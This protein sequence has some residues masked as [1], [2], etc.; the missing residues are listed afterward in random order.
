MRVP[1][2]DLKRIV[3][4]IREEIL[5]DW[6][7]CLDNTEFVGGPGVQNLEKKLEAY[8]E[9]THVVA[10]A[11]GTDALVIGL[12][13]M[14]IGQGHKVAVPNMT[15]WAPY[16]A[17]VQVGATPV[18][19]DISATDLQMNFDEFKAGHEKFKFDAAIL[20][21]LFGWT[22]THLEEYRAYCKREG[23]R[24]L[25]DG[26]QAFGVKK[27]GRHVYSD[28]EIST[29]SFYPAKVLG[30][31]G[32][33]GAIMTPDPKL[34]DKI[35]SLCNHGRAGHYTYDYVGWNSRLS[36]LQ[37]RFLSRMLDRIDGMLESRVKAEKYYQDYFAGFTHDCIVHKAPAGVTTN[38][39]L[40]VLESKHFSGDDLSASLRDQGIGSARTYPQTLDEQPP[41]RNALRTS[42]LEHSK[43]FSRMV[44]NLPLFAG[45]TMEE[46]QASAEALKNALESPKHI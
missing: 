41:A 22:S 2:I 31:A 10:C 9:T 25:E 23:I 32:D 28:A 1:F 19:V 26:A 15:F 40:F 29:I 17:I 8:L 46:C 18:L 45:I 34:A 13:A 14:G 33:A 20:V 38:G 21:H 7:N 16:E 35:R 11:N 3:T 5:Q 39:Y 24:L 6:T 4:P 30:A 44:I 43:R 36:G 37:A 12:Q 27:N 42:N